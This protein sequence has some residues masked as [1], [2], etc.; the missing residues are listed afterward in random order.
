MP[1]SRKSPHR[2]NERFPHLTHLL[3][4]KKLTRGEILPLFILLLEFLINKF[5]VFRFSEPKLS[6]AVKDINHLLPIKSDPNCPVCTSPNRSQYERYYLLSGK[7]IEWVLSYVHSQNEPHITLNNLRKHFQKHFNPQTDISKASQKALGKI[8]SREGADFVEN[9]LA[10]FIFTDELLGKLE[11]RI[12]KLIEEERE[13]PSKEADLLKSL[14]IT[15]L[16]YA[17]WLRDFKE[18]EEVENL[19]ELFPLG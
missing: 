7:D 4:K 3:K 2:S 14:L 16:R 17:S 5:E 13:I 11:Q 12:K 8:V 15:L 10:H 19:G 18:D 6:K 1:D 9:V